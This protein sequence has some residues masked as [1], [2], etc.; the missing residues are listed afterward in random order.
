[1]V[2]T[3]TIVVYVSVLNHVRCKGKPVAQ[4]FTGTQS[5]EVAYDRIDAAYSI[6]MDI[7]VAVGAR[8]RV[9]ARFEEVDLTL[10]RTSIGKTCIS[11]NARCEA[12]KVLFPF[13]GVS[14]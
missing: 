12:T 2:K 1:M 14:G 7:F 10:P 4:S 8:S 13:V 9:F 5:S 3:L 6:A 11:V